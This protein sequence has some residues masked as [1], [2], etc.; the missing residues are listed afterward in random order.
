[1]FLKIKDHNA[2]ERFGNIFLNIFSNKSSVAYT[3]I[4][5]TKLD[6]KRTSSNVKECLLTGSRAD[7]IGGRTHI[8]SFISLPNSDHR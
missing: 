6:S 4:L 2:K 3:Y 8:E 1:M 5:D 7:H